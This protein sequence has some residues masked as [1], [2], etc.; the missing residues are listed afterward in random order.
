MYPAD[1][2]PMGSGMGSLRQSS[3]ASRRLHPCIPAPL[4]CLHP[5]AV[6]PIIAP[7]WYASDRSALT[8][9]FNINVSPGNTGT[10]IR[11]RCSGSHIACPPAGTLLPHPPRPTLR[12]QDGFGYATVCCMFMLGCGTCL[13]W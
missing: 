7:C 13:L 11:K 8:Q 9:K 6:C 3:A 5:S 4:P 12:L 10:P 2:E 1:A